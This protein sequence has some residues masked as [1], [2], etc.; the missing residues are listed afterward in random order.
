MTA[1]DLLSI[2]ILK[3]TV[4]ILFEIAQ[5]YLAAFAGKDTNYVFPVV[6]QMIEYMRDNGFHVIFGIRKVVRRFADQMVG[7]NMG[8]YLAAHNFEQIIL[9]FK[10]RVKGTSANIRLIKDFL[11]RDI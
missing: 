11:H 3:N 1:P 10:M 5:E 6:P 7:N 2:M 4:Q 8:E 9:R